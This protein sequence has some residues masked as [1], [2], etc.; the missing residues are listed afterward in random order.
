MGA[1]LPKSHEK[2]QNFSWVSRVSR[3]RQLT[4]LSSGC[5]N[6]EAESQQTARPALQVALASCKQPWFLEQAAESGFG[7]SILDLA[8]RSREGRALTV[9]VTGFILMGLKGR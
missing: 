4:G 3:D 7:T 1:C 9:N 6:N 2:V 8:E 5:V